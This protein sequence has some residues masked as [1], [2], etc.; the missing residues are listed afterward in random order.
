MRFLGSKVKLLSTIEKV[1]KKHNIKGETF[2]DLFAG[3][4]CVGDYFKDRF[5]IISN[6]TLFSAYIINCAKL[7][8][9]SVPKFN[10]FKVYKSGADIFSWL[11]SLSFDPNETYFFYNNYSPIGGRMFFTKENS[12]KIDGIRQVIEDLYNKDILSLTEYYFLIASLIESITKVSNTSGTYEAFFKFWE[13]RAEKSFKI[14]P[15]EMKFS[16]I[17]KKK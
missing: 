9:D 4:G 2:A 17:N 13:S 5:K 14:E 6:D 10:K 8:N 12:I 1:I 7:Q 15:L 11:N 16:K 3:T